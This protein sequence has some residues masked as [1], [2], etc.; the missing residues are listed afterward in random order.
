MSFFLLNVARI[1]IIIWLNYLYYR[2]MAAAIHIENKRFNCSHI[3]PFILPTWMWVAGGLTLSLTL[4]IWVLTL[5][6]SSFIFTVFGLTTGHLSHVNFFDGDIPRYIHTYIKFYNIIFLV[7]K[8][9][10]WCVT[11]L[12]PYINREDYSNDQ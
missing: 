11:L 3:I 7:Y 1:A 5:M 4:S 9:H 2:Y 6:I 8:C 12:L 10:S